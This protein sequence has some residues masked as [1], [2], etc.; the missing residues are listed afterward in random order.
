MSEPLTRAQGAF[1]GWL[2]AREDPAA[3]PGL[4]GDARASAAERLGVYRN[5]YSA[6]IISALGDDFPALKRALGDA[7]FT[8]L[9][10]AYLH[11]NPSQHPS[12]RYAGARLP[13]FIAEHAAPAAAELRLSAPW[14]ADLARF[15]LAVTDAF[16][17]V[18]SKL[19]TRADLTALPPELW[20][21][22]ALAVVPGAQLLTL[23]WPVRAVRAAHDAEQP[24][25]LATLAAAAECVF[26]WRR[27]E[28]VMHRALEASEATLLARAQH[29]VRFGELCALAAEE[30][31]DEAGAAFAASVLGRWVE[32]GVLVADDR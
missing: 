16:D 3:T 5:A 4:F 6:R 19:L 14:A 27:E 23:A 11:A 10:A 15:E 24:L 13:A 22:L 8:A 7:C 30:R 29:G 20:D 21:Q 31:A 2:M 18:D 26:V 1:A 12:L 17:A 28:R 9:A 25:A 32:D